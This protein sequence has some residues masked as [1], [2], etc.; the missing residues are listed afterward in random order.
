MPSDDPAAPSRLDAEALAW[1]SN[2]AVQTPAQLILGAYDRLEAAS[3]RLLVI[4]WDDD[5][6]NDIF[7][8]LIAL[9]AYYRLAERIASDL[10]M[11]L[12]RPIIVG[13][14]DSLM[15]SYTGTSPTWFFETH[16]ALRAFE[17][18]GY[19]R[20]NPKILNFK[21]SPTINVALTI[22]L[23]II[24]SLAMISSPVSAGDI[25]P[26]VALCDQQ[27]MGMPTDHARDQIAEMLRNLYKS[28]L[29]ADQ[30]TKLAQ[31]IIGSNS[32]ISCPATSRPTIQV[33]VDDHISAVQKSHGLR[34]PPS[35]QPARPR[36][37]RR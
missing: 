4:V 35:Y 11:G 7:N 36:G 32:E 15:P 30:M 25:P 34:L 37:G 2:R 27:A 26:P 12:P 17:F 20:V 5:G 6:A 29:P 18:E 33:T 16:A 28:G 31:Q 14:S 1:L 19:E 23:R 3:D 22:P 8:A 13:E 10:G 24:F 21:F 9:S